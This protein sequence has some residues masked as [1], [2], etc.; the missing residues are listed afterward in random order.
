MATEKQLIKLETIQK[1]ANTARTQHKD[2]PEYLSGGRIGYKKALR[3]MITTGQL[4]VFTP[5]LACGVVAVKTVIEHAMTYNW[6]FSTPEILLLS[7]T[8][9]VSVI[10]IVLGYK[11]WCLDVTPIFALVS[12]LIILV[13]NI[14]L[15]SG[16]LPLITVIS[17]IVS[18]IRYSTFCTWFHN[19]K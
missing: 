18:L 5:M 14:C 10:S 1:R 16:I 4:A 6:Y 8:L 9:A 17:A 7:A 11:L 3:S 2:I 12:L 15:F 13:C 19:F